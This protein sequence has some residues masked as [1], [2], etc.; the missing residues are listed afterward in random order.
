MAEKPFLYVDNS[1]NYNVFV[2]ALKQ[3]SSGVDWAGGNPAG[4][5]L[6]ISQFYITQP[7]DSAETINAQL[8]AGKN[9]IVTPGIYHLD[10]PLNVTRADTVIVGL[11][12]ATLQPT[13]GTSAIN[14]A[15]VNGVKVGGLLI[16]AGQTNSPILM[17]VG[18]DRLER[19]PLGR[20]DHPV[21]RALPHRRRGRRHRPPSRW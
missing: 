21:R 3:N 9:L 6:P 7:G 13:N 17:Q 1:G 12:L 20:P 19:R 10:Q 11:G 4:T 15:D 14:V 5:S 16:D 2:P 8:A 18:P